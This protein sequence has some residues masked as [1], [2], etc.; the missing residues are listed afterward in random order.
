MA[1]D[2][3]TGTTA[4][5]PACADLWTAAIAHRDGTAPDPAVHARALRKLLHTP[6]LLLVLRD[7][8][9]PPG[10]YTLTH[11]PTG[12]D[13]TAH[14]THIA[15]APALQGGGRGRRLLEATLARLAETA[16]AVTL[17]VLHTNT[18]ARALYESTGWHPVA[19]TRFADSG[20]PAVLYRKT[21]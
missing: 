7:P 5:H 14:L 21:L 20:R 19:H 17:Q 4:D 16:D 10:G 1:P 11:L 6:R 15:I 3:T 13:R 12:T 9:R 8:D 18:T 2:I